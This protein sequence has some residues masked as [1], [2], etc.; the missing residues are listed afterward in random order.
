MNLTPTLKK[1]PLGAIRN[2]PIDA[3]IPAQGLNQL[4]VNAQTIGSLM[5][6]FDAVDEAR[7]IAAGEPHLL[8]QRIE[9]VGDVLLLESHNLN[10]SV[11]RGQNQKVLIEVHVPHETRLD[12]HLFAGVVMLKGGAGD[13]HID[14]KFGEITGVTLAQNVDIRLQAG[15]VGFNDLRGVANIRV[16]FGAVALGWEKLYGAEKIDI[17]C[18]CG[19]IDLRLPPSATAEHDFGGLLQD[20]TLSLPN[21]THIHARVNFG[22]LDISHWQPKRTIKASIVI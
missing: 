20:K 13:V 19:A 8:P 21:S 15:D 4:H 9:R 1:F 2:P 17:S 10:T 14:G 11:Q 22:A 5:I 7:V 18:G 16:A 6:C 3:K 12:L